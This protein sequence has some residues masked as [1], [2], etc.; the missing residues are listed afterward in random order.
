ME[1]ELEALVVYGDG[2]DF[3]GEDIFEAPRLLGSFW[4]VISGF[5]VQSPEAL[6]RMCQLTDALAR[7]K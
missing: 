5:W 1:G 3:L 2:F 6:P 7:E 4:G